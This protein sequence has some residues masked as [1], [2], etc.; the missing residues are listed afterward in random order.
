MGSDCVEAPNARLQNFTGGDVGIGGF[1]WRSQVLR[2]WPAWGR[3]LCM[4]VGWTG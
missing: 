3:L 2:G 1:G 4:V